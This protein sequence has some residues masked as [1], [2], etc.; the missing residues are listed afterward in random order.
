MRMCVGCHSTLYH[1]L[2]KHT[3]ETVIK[4]FRASFKDACVTGGGAYFAGDLEK[5]AYICMV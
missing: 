1:V 4:P 3:S 5:P 2:L